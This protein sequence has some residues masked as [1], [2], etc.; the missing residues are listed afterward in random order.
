MS[1]IAQVRS[2]NRTI[3][4]QV[5]ALEAH[6]LDT[7]RSLAACR[8]LFEIGR[9]GQDLVHL[10]ASLGLDSGYLSRLLR[11]LEQE[12]LV[13]TGG[14]ARDSRIRRASL[15]RA[16]QRELDRLN[17]KSDAAAGALLRRLQPAQRD[18]LVQAMATVERLIIA[19]AV[20]IRLES[21]NSPAARYCLNSYFAEIAARFEAGFDPGRSPTPAADFRAPR[22]YFLVAWLHGDPIGCAGLRCGPTYGE[23][24]RMWVA[25]QARGL[26]VGSRLLQR[27]EE[28]A[29][30]RGL[31]TLRL[32]TNKALVEAQSLYRKL[33]FQEVPAFNTEPYAH[34]WF[35]KPLGGQE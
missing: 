31:A 13:E 27:L 34:F 32:E 19:S 7:P 12:G 3:T 25:P 22:G 18:T 16:G 6:F 23:V 15:T 14:S 30:K 29:R 1:A 26:G 5:G 17:Q 9:S 20:E 10:R 35:E 2:F 4:R 21:L 11:G 28:L 24:K 8:L 33:G